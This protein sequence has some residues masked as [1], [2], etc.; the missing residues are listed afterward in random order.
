MRRKVG[1]VQVR[2]LASLV[3]GFDAEAAT[4]IGFRVLGF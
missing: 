4:G 1:L 3:Q 2:V